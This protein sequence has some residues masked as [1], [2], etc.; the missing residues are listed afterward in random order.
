MIDRLLIERVDNG[1]TVEIEQQNI[2][3]QHRLVQYVFPRTPGDNDL[4]I[5]Q[6]IEEA[7]ALWNRP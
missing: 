1:F 3:G 5:P 7:V 2:L 4:T 6:V